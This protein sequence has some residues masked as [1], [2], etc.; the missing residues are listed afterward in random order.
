MNHMIYDHMN[1]NS[2]F[3]I[4]SDV[5]FI[6][7]SAAND[8]LEIGSFWL[9]VCSWLPVPSNG[10]VNEPS[11]RALYLIHLDRGMEYFFYFPIELNFLQSFLA[12]RK[13]LVAF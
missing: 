5:S 13:L 2:L 7:V 1:V 4:Y 6:C 11:L 9:N 8:T 12:Q 10:L 3:T